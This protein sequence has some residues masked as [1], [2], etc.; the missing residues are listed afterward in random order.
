MMLFQGDSG[1]PLHCQLATG[2]WVVAGISSWGSRACT[3]YPSVF[4]RV[5]SFIDWINDV[6]EHDKY[7]NERVEGEEDV[8]ISDDVNAVPRDRISPEQEVPL[9]GVL[10]ENAN[11]IDTDAGEEER[12]KINAP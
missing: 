11:E 4:T 3:T 10:I 6:T 9:F 8:V 1:S 12:N 7:G 2:Q 5:T